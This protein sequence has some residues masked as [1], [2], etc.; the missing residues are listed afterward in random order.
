MRSHDEEMMCGDEGLEALVSAVACSAEAMPDGARAEVR[1]RLLATIEPAAVPLRIR[2][3]RP[4]IALATAGALLG[5]VSYAAAGSVPGQPLFGL[6]QSIVSTV[7]SAQSVLAHRTIGKPVP[8]VLTPVQAPTRDPAPSVP[9]VGEAT[10]KVAAPAQGKSSGQ[11]KGNTARD[12]KPKSTK[13][14]GGGR[15]QTHRSTRDSK[16]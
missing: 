15:K 5:G 9:Q 2:L 4:V 12:S 11:G 6:K 13:S 14:H 1:E 8:A 7:R 16:R 10:P 3:L